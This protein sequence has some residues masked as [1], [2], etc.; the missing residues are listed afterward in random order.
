MTTPLMRRT[1]DDLS[2]A[3]G[4][5]A[6]FD[7]FLSTGLNMTFEQ[8]LEGQ[9]LEGETVC[10][11]FARASLEVGDVDTYITDVVLPF[12]YSLSGVEEDVLKM[13]DLCLT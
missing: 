10:E 12:T 1:G 7:W 5:F 9:L 4:A 13:V 11:L 3:V 2:R 6:L 8:F